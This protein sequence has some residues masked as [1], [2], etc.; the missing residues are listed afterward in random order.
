MMNSYL[1]TLTPRVSVIN[2]PHILCTEQA[3]LHLGSCIDQ[4]QGHNC[5][6]QESLTIS[7]IVDHRTHTFPHQNLVIVYM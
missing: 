7:L 5:G 4:S 6:L 2:L 1:S 3:T